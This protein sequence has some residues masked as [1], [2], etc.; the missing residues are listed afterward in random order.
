MMATV[1]SMGRLDIDDKAMTNVD[2]G[3]DDDDDSDDDNFVSMRRW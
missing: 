3:N 1:A 2:K